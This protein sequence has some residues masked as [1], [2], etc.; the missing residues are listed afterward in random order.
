MKKKIGILTQP[1]S[2]NYG[3]LIQAFALQ[4]F[5]MKRG[6]EVQVINRV[7]KPVS[8]FR[9]VLSLFKTYLSYFL[10]SRY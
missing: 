8:I 1:L 9:F 6:Y 4:K 3:G 2:T 5:L 7:F 10:I